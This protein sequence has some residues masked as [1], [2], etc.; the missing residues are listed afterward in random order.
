M[1]KD[2]LSPSEVDKL[3]AGRTIVDNTP[4]HEEDVD[5]SDSYEEEIEYG[6]VVAINTASKAKIDYE[7]MG[8]FDI[9]ST[10]YFSGY[11]VDHIDN[12]A[13]ITED[14]IFSTLVS[15][16]N[17]LMFK[18]PNDDEDS[19]IEDMLVEELFETLV[20]VKAQFDTINHV[21]RWICDCQTGIDEKDKVINETQVNLKELNYVS[22]EQADEKYRELIRDKFAIPEIFSFYIKKKYGEGEVASDYNVE[23]ELSKLQI[24]EP[25]TITY[26]EH[27]IK[28]SFMKIQ[29]ILDS[30][31]FVNKKY[32]PKIKAIK[33][34]QIHNKK[35]HELKEIKEEELDRL[36]N[37][38]SKD[39]LRALKASTILEYNG[40]TLNTLEEKIAVY[41]T[42]SMSIYVELSD[43]L[44]KIRF[45]IQHEHTFECPICGLSEKRWLQQQFNFVEFLPTKS[46]TN[47]EVR[48]IT[49]GNIFMGI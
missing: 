19:K 25:Y 14:N 23:T 5:T 2:F 40:R 33:N 20:S 48:S 45:G 15:I 43:F 10:L 38:K 17:D 16:L 47:N 6:K 11:T 24:E 26:D 9:P 7:T 44:E 8:R 31:S 1:N 21:H 12:F 36:H 3:K 39:F 29:N 42:L 34:K 37:E 28:F 41:K 46:D 32:N 27:I 35:A 30:H 4:S 13:L 49:R 22:I 18:N